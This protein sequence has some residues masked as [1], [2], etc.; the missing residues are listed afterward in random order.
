MTAPRREDLILLV[1][2]SRLSLLKKKLQIVEGLA[3]IGVLTDS[4]F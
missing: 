3:V 4:L 1:V 2:D